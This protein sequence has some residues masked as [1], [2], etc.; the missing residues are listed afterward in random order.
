MRMEAITN[1]EDMVR[2]TTSVRSMRTARIPTHESKLT[3]R[4]EDRLLQHMHTD[5]EVIE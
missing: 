4:R 1:G 3:L 2:S 5:I